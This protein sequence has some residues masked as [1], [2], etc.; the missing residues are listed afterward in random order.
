LLKRTHYSRQGRV[1]DKGEDIEF[2][3]PPLDEA[4]AK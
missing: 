4:L 3:E 1:E 2:L